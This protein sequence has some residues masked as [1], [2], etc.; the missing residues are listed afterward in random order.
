[1]SPAHWSSRFGRRHHIGGFGHELGQ[2]GRGE[3]VLVPVK[4]DHGRAVDDPDVA[5]HPLGIGSRRRGHPVAAGDGEL[6]RAADRGELDLDVVAVT[7][8]DDVGAAAADEH[9]VAGAADSTSSPSPPTRTS[10]PWPPSAVSWIAPACRPE[11]STTSSPAS[12]LTVSRSLAAS[13]PV[14]FTCADSPRTDVP[15]ASPDTRMTSSPLV[16]LTTTLSGCAVAPAAGHRQVG[17]DLGHVGPGKVV[18]DDRVGATEGVEVDGFDVV[19]VHRDV[20]DVAEEPHPPAVG[21]DVDVL[22]DVGAVEEH[23]VAAGLAL[24]R[25]VVVARV[26]D[27]RVVARAHQ[28]HVVAVAADDQV[29]T[30]AAEQVVGAEPAVLRELDPVGFQGGGVDDVIA[31]EAVERQAVV[32]LLLEGDVH[33]RRR[34]R[35]HRPRRRHRRRRTRRHRSCR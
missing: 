16:A 30:L 29:V 34:A 20:G 6:G 17:V 11:A 12:A 7:A 13:A 21:G 23:R 10:S 31:A 33:R 24:E 9:V 27:E 5:Q 35:R 15:E 8:V 19:E 14:M 18:D 22:G 28:C 32:G 25:V 2:V 3:P 1:M 26:P 4:R